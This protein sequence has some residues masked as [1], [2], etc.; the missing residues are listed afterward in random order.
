LLHV[1]F[2]DGLSIP[3][4][5]N[6]G[7]FTTGNEKSLLRSKAPPASFHTPSFSNSVAIGH[8]LA[9]QSFK[10][11]GTCRKELKVIEMVSNRVY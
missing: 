2:K 1:K 11:K 8:D 7:N 10:M 9:C 4:L 5:K 3:V 6:R